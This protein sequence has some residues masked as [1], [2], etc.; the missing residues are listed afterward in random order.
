LAQALLAGLAMLLALAAPAAAE[1]RIALVIGNGAYTAAQ[2]LNNP[3]RD[4]PAIAGVLKRAGF[5]AITLSLD[6]DQAE[7]RASLQ[8]F[9]RA[10]RTADVAAVYF[11]GHGLE[12]GGVN[13]LV[14]VDARLETDA[15]VAYEA[16]PLELVM[17]AVGGARRLGLVMMD[18]CRNNPFVARMAVRQGVQRSLGRGLARV[19][20]VGNTLVVYAARDGT[21]AADGDGNHSPFAQ[22]LLRRLPTPGVE[23]GLVFRQVRDDVLA[24]TGGAQQPFTYGSIGGGAF[25]FVGGPAPAS[26][27][28]PA[29]RP[30]APEVAAAPRDIPPP[31]PSPRSAGGRSAA[32]RG[33]SV[34][35][36]SLGEQRDGSGRQRFSATVEFENANAADVGVAILGDQ[37]LSPQ[38]RLGD[39]EGGECELMHY[40]T[41]L[42]TH[43]LTHSGNNNAF[44]MVAGSGSARYTMFF[45]D[46][47]APPTAREGLALTGSFVLLVDDRAIEFPFS[48]RDLSLRAPSR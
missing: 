19:E 16:I 24:A 27:R 44:V 35:L 17:D 25:Y 14:P 3:G 8:A 41:T 37:A 10:A 28:A 30:A 21:T 12:M 33:M 13:Y 7:M 20:P 15:D 23:L 38:I 2:R 40:N 9:A 26:A 31:L 32:R 18:A 42:R 22:A 1:T 43:S 34:T 5:S 36:L 45:S 6:A 29:R 48:F 46:C 47:R 39:A 4:A 11:A